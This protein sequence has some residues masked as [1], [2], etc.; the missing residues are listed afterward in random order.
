MVNGESSPAILYMFGIMRSRPCEA[1]KVVESAPACNAP[2]TAPA[3]PPSDCISAISGI[4][5]QRFVL[6]LL[7][8]SSHTSAMGEL[9]VMGKIAI[10]S[11]RRKATEAAAS[12][13]ST[14]IL[15]FVD[16]T[17]LPFYGLL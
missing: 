1:V 8:H 2:C 5:P 6:P 12:F 3:A 13:P 4:T 10:A 17:H 7:A 14:V 11:L 15:L 16:V 9:G